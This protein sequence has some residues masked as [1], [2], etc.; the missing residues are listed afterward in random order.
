MM[1]VEMTQAMMVTTMQGVLESLDWRVET[2]SK[3]T[4]H[5]TVNFTIIEKLKFSQTV[6][7]SF[8]DVLEISCL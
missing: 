8:Y 5:A 4:S 6:D 3:P 2:D 1:S 7:R